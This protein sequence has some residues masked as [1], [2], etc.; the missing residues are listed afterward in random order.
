MIFA[1]TRGYLDGI[2]T[3]RLQEWVHRFLG[4]LHEKHA[5]ISQ[6]IRDTGALSDDVQKQLI[7]AIE[8]FNKGF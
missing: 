2:E 8:D 6:T 7:A 5:D 4:V 3:S 1:A